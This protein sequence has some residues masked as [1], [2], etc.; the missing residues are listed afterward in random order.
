MA[1]GAVDLEKMLSPL[2]AGMAQPDL[3]SLVAFGIMIMIHVTSATL[4]RGICLPLLPQAGSS[5][6]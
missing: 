3:F 6:R 1:K 5:K 2:S 4:K